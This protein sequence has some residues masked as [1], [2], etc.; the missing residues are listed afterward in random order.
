MKRMAVASVMVAWLALG[1]PVPPEQTPSFM[2]WTK[3]TTN[4][5]IVFVTTISEV[6]GVR[7]DSQFL[8]LRTNL[9]FKTASNLWSNT[10]SSE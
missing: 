2:R 9:M 6:Q 5:T 1:Q 4:V 3:Y 10:T 8:A 7:V